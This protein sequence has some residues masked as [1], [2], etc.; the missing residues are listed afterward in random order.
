MKK[1]EGKVGSA[2]WKV[3]NKQR[4]INAIRDYITGKFTW[5]ELAKKHH[6]CSP[7]AAHGALWDTLR[8]EM[9]VET[10]TVKTEVNH[11]YRLLH[12]KL[13]KQ[14]IGTGKLTDDQA[15]DKLLKLMEAWSKLNGFMNTTK[16]KVSEDLQ[17]LSRL[18]D[19]ELAL[20][21]K[22]LIEKIQSEGKDPKDE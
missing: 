4:R 13:R 10:E 1:F 12:Q 7:Q 3:Y 19:E 18:T 17:E 2:A 9:A 6:Y 22:E 8:K 20:R 11:T 16:V 21:K 15:T 14:I 5:A